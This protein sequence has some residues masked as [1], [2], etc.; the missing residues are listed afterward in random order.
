VTSKAQRILDAKW[1]EM[2]AAA[3]KREVCHLRAREYEEDRQMWRQMRQ[4]CD[5]LQ[6]RPI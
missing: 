3:S 5:M 4:G 2:Q 1:S 6:G